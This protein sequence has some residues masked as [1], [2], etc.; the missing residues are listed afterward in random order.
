MRQATKWLAL[1]LFCNTPAEVVSR[2]YS[3]TSF[4][5]I[6]SR[7]DTLQSIFTR[8]G[9]DKSDLYAMLSQ[10]DRNKVSSIKPG[11][12]IHFDTSDGKRLT[13]MKVFRAHGDVVVVKR[14]AGHYKLAHDI[15]PEVKV[16]GQFHQVGFQLKRSLYADGKKQGLS[17]ANLAEIDRVMKMDPM[18]DPKRL[19]PGTK[20]EVTLEGELKKNAKNNV[21]AIDVTQGKKNWHVT[22]F[23][24]KYSHQ[25]YHD[26]GSTAAVNFLKYPMKSF[27]I[28]SPF[29]AS[30][31]HPILGYKRAHNGVDYAAPTGTAIWSTAEGVVEF[32]GNRGGY[33]KAIIVKHGENYKTLY[34]HLSGFSKGLKKGDRVKQKQVI[35]YVG[36]TGHATGPHLHYE[37]RRAGVPLDP[38]RAKLPVKAK[39]K[40][41]LL[42]A[43]QAYQGSINTALSMKKA[44]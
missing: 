14:S 33:G 12:L 1:L 9:L 19:L 17:A 35:G 37:L 32:V 40:G 4:D 8:Y 44:K 42:K 3:N 7:R 43:F 18:I 38:L 24:D 31:M 23:H 34:A 29:S 2:P 25:F 28:S 30:R 36:K 10:V 27:R 41:E 15:K 21:V 11:Q 26:D 16:K 6:V 22:R 13:G 5:V 39:L 20:V